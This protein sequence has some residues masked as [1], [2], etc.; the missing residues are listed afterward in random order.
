MSGDVVCLSVCLSSF[1]YDSRPMPDSLLELLPDLVLLMRRDGS[2]L[3]RAGGHAVPDLRVPSAGP[4]ETPWSDATSALIRQLLRRSL[5]DR[6]ASEARFHERGRDY[7]IRVTAQ[8]PDR[9]VVAIRPVLRTAADEAV[10]TT[11]ERRLAALD[12]RGFLKRFRESLSVASLREKSL[13]V[14]VIYLDGIPD[15]S[16]VIASRVSDQVMS[17]AVLRLAALA[18]QIPESQPSW[19]LGQ[20]SENILAVVIDSAEREVVDATVGSICASL[21]E[22]VAAGDAEYRLTPYAGVGVLGLDA[23]TPKVLLDHARAAA[24]EARRAASAAVHFHSDTIQLR[25]LARLD[26]A[27]ELR[28]GVENGEIGFRYVG[29]HDLVTGELVTWVGYLRWLHPLRGDIRPA[30]FLRVAESTGLA[31]ALSRAALKSLARDFTALSAH[32]GPSVRISFGALRDHLLHE[33]FLADMERMLE[34][35][36][37]P[38]DRLELRIAEKSFV[39]RDAADF[40]VLQKRKIQLVVDEV[41]RGAGSIAA[42]ARAPVWGLQTDRAWI[43]AVREDAIARKVCQ[44]TLGVASALGLR[45]IAVGVDDRVLR[46]TLLEMGYRFGSGDLFPARKQDISAPIAAPVP[47]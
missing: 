26:L 7:E 14:A 6:A 15:I 22:P 19:Y 47:A 39:A 20:L 45:P 24:A 38:A 42:M 2:V 43:T 28:E 1:A 33:D 18:N 13:A 27:R 41:G 16:Q 32:A 34:E 31:V 12:R 46:D 23:T 8:G 35:G 5:A 30:E 36:A 4:F 17:T 25:S 9:A 21:R 44:A 40:R 3:A 11:G 10:E 37:I 29:R